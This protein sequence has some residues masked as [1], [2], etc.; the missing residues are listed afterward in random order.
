MLTTTN[1]HTEKVFEDELCTQLQA[2]GWKVL[3]H[4]KGAPQNSE[5]KA[6]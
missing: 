2:T 3:T 6:R 1:V 4:L 5:F